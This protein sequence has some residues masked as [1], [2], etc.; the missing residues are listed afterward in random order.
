MRWGLFPKRLSSSLPSHFGLHNARIESVAQRKTFAPLLEA[1]RRAVLLLSGFYE[2]STLSTGRKQPFYIHEESAGA[3]EHVMMV[4]VVY[5]ERVGTC[6]L[7]TFAI[8]TMD[9]SD[10]ITSIHHRQPVILDVESAAVW[11]DTGDFSAAD[12]V[13]FVHARAKSLSMVFHAVTPLMN[14]RTYQEADCTL[15]IDASKQSMKQF[16]PA[17]AVEGGQGGGR[18]GEGEAAEEGQGGAA[19]KPAL[20]PALAASARKHCAEKAPVA[21]TRTKSSAFAW[22]C[23]KCTFKNDPGQ[24][25]CFICR[26]QRATGGGKSS[27]AKSSGGGKG[28]AVATATRGLADFFKASPRAGAASAT[29]APAPAAPAAAAP[30]AAAPAAAAPAAAAKPANAFSMLGKRPRTVAVAT[31]PLAANIL[32][33]AKS[34][35]NKS[36]TC[37]VLPGTNGGS[38]LLHLREFLDSSDCD[39]NSDCFKEEWELQ[40]R[41][42][43]VLGSGA[44]ENRLSQFYSTCGKKEFTYSGMTSVATNAP[45]FA[46]KMIA[47]ANNLD[48]A[49]AGAHDACLVNWYSATD[50]HDIGA[51]SDDEKDHVKSRPIFSFSAGGKRR[52]LIA[53]IRGHPDERAMGDKLELEMGAGDLVVM[54]G[55]MQSTHTHAVPKFRKRTDAWFHRNRI[56]Y[57]VRCFA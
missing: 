10:A 9:A 47:I 48:T 37:H 56:N 36:G 17:T 45:P 22:K 51:H 34:H 30:A 54:G 18:G 24:Q 53:P 43:K 5:E 12:A 49:A 21:T 57:T 25:R 41:E 19:E 16:F 33:A 42:R 7:P 23:S 1:G 32:A 39:W 29:T 46:A 11:L 55:T 26:A 31:P 38:W 13:E 6:P 14:K 50:N 35:Y 2:W 20:V 8:L 52:F 3:D 27:G 44:R 4:A 28:A 40:P 15:D